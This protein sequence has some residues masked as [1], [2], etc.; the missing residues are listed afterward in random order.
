MRNCFFLLLILILGL[1]EMTVLNYIGVFNLKPDLLLASVLIVSIFLDTLPAL[2]LS[3]LA[4]LF[5]DVFS[6]QT[7]GFN[8]FFFGVWSLVIVRASKEFSLEG[9]WVLVPVIFIITFL[10]YTLTG[11]MA[12]YLGT[13]VPFGVFLRVLFVESFFTA[14]SFPLLFR[15]VKKQAQILN[16]IFQRRIFI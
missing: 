16:K 4:G 6:L 12:L 9:D 2:F 7:F 15:I 8:T 10:H 1:L 11:L 3:I 14:L 5:K 13:W